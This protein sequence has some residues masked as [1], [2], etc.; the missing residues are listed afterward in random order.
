MFR[1]WFPWRF[2]LKRTARAYGFLDPLS[3]L[4]R[5]RRFAQPSEVQEPLEL[6]RAGL[7]FH[8]RGLINTK[9]IQH[10]LDWVWPY[11]VERQFDPQDVSFIPRAFSIT[12]VN[13]T[14]RNWTAVGLPGFA[15]YPI[16]DPRGLVTPLLD[17]WS[18]DVWVLSEDGKLLSPSRC[19]ATE[20]RLLHA[21][22]LCVRTC[23]RGDALESR[24]ESF[25]ELSKG[26]PHLNLKA[27]G[28]SVKK[29]WLLIMLRPYNPEGIQFLEK[30]EY[31]KKLPGWLVN[32]QTPVMMEQTPQKVLFS[33][34]E[35]G[36][37]LTRLMDG[38]AGDQIACD[39]GMATS[40]AFFPVPKGG[41]NCVQIRVPLGKAPPRGH[42]AA[43][44]VSQTWSESLQNAAR[45][46]VPDGAIRELYE[47]AVRTLILLSARDVIPGPYTYCR[48]WFRDACL[49][50]NA[51]LA[52]GLVERS[53]QALSRFFDR[54]ERS[55]YFK[56][57]TG[58]WDSN[59]QVLWILGRFEAL[60]QSKLPSDWVKAVFRGAHWIARKRA[61]QSK[62]SPHAGLLAAG[63]SAEHLGPNDYYYWDDFWA[64]SGLETAARIAGRY[65]FPAQEAAFRREA[66]DLEQSIW[67]SIGGISHKMTNGGIPASPY[68]R[69]DSGAVGSLVAD[70]PLQVTPPGDNQIRATIHFLMANSFH[71]GAFFQDMVHSGI[72]TYLTLAI[73]QSLLRMGDSRYRSL[74]RTCAQMASETGQWP[75]A[76]HPHTGGGCMG[77]GQ[78]GWA[79]AEWVMMIRNL[80]VRE[81]GDSLI[82]G[83]GLFPEWLESGK[84][85]SFGPTPTA[86]GPVTLSVVMEGAKPAVT[87]EAERQSRFPR[88]EI[89]IPGYKS[90]KL[91]KP[92][93]KYIL[94]S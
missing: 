47:A 42:S 12:H 81:E 20:Q 41:A 29:G 30:I 89:R 73:G 35:D 32:S 51:M 19:D 85:L 15:L 88:A 24:T 65:G 56:S 67:K 92:A 38:P 2:I 75:E 9:A 55:G 71:K 16:V 58:E 72:N 84:K 14:H 37:V 28:K 13:L 23:C 49:M 82:L 50:L 31:D 40:A 78:H 60:S 10:N 21:N 69:M 74:I 64:L 53:R 63:F 86:Q 33:R 52:A 91:R 6:L 90:L 66:G 62:P 59:G 80:F 18:L 1:R 7:V 25:V 61:S 44:A 70:Y 36:D 11:W 26:V 93:G 4:A 79:A 48:F 27:E 46:R 76:I 17:G 3:V 8:A 45:L 39:V 77:D 83:S 94:G 68:R 22:G 57:Q 54:Q 5:L 87:V 34:Y 43:G